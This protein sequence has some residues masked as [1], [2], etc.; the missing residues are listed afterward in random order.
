MLRLKEREYRNLSSPL[1]ILQEDTNAK[2]IDSDFYVEGYATTFTRYKL[3]EWDGIE[4]FE[5]IAPDAF[6]SADMTDVIMQYDHMGK[7]LARQS[8]GT[9]GLEVDSKGLF[10]YADL[11]KSAAAKEMYEEISTG[12]VTRMSWAF[13]I[14]E[15]S[16]NKDTR[17]WTIRKIKKVYD[18]SA[19]S[20]PANDDTN[21]SA[22][23]LERRSCIQAGQERLGLKTRL[24][25]L[26]LKMEV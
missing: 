18:V 9:L 8:N 22:R 21:I 16:Y 25:Q 17:T 1:T 12:L 19:V 10:V 20:I 14:L 24:L 15:E 2:R 23:G 11:S 13:L 4:Y 7:V 3:Y 6:D 26:K 5:E